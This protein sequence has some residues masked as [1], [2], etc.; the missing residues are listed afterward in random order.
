M[1]YPG[2]RLAFK[3]DCSNNEFDD[4]T[5]D[6]YKRTFVKD[7]FIDIDLSNSNHSAEYE[8]AIPVNTNPSSTTFYL[9]CD[10]Q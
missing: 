1:G 7:W 5:P 4:Q 8:F 10:L 3:A 2:E 9:G 6:F